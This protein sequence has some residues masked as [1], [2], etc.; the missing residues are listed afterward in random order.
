MTNIKKKHLQNKM[1]NL[2]NIE[3]SN[4]SEY[5]AR[6]IGYFNKL[7]ANNTNINEY[8]IINYHF[9]LND[10]KEKESQKI[11]HINYGN[12]KNLVIKRYSKEILEYKYINLLSYSEIVL[13]LAKVYKVKVSKST[14]QKLILLNKEHYNG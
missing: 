13:K 8:H 6:S 9:I 11:Q 5:I 12:I 4:I 14:I 1:I 3:E 2:L 10:I 7:L